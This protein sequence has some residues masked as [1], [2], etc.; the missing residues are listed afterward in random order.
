MMDLIILAIQPNRVVIVPVSPVGAVVSE[1]VLF[2]ITESEADPA[3]PAPTV[4]P[5]S[6]DFSKDVKSSVESCL[7]DTLSTLLES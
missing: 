1:M 7:P 3:P 4:S 2:P 6:F 5:A